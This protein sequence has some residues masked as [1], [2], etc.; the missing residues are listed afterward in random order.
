MKDALAK[1]LLGGDSDAQARV[2]QATVSGTSPTEVTLGGQD[3]IPA[4]TCA[5]YTPAVG[6]VVVCIQLGSDLIIIDQIISGG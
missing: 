3:G 6:D 4:A 1:V 5:N 2:R